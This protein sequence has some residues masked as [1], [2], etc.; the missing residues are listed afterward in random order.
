[1]PVE[2]AADLAGMFGADEFAENA[3]YVAPVAGAVA[4]ACTVIVDRGQ[5]RVAQRPGGEFETAASERMLW[6]RRAELASVVRDGLFRMRNAA[7]DETGEVF[8]VAA[9]P[10][11]DHSAAL[12]SVELWIAE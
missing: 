8:R 6:A 9:L 1:M 7:G 12:W 10:R 3:G 5:G 4:V 2:S 11:L